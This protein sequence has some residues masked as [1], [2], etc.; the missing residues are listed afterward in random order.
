MPS[1]TRKCGRE[2]NSAGSNY[3]HTKAIG[4]PYGMPRSVGKPNIA[5]RHVFAE[6][7]AIRPRKDRRG[8]DLISD[9]LTFGRLWYGEPNAVSNA[10]DYE[11]IA[12]ANM[13]RRSAFDT[14]PHPTNIH[15][16]VMKHLFHCK[17]CADDSCFHLI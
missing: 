16:Q 13:M 1:A 7:R 11:S 14:R 15:P 10:V 17:D 2:T 6:R 12:A 5:K 9:A 3:W 4:K 8:V